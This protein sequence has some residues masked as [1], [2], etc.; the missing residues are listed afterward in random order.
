M[1]MAW[2]ASAAV[3]LQVVTVTV[4]GSTAQSK[5]RDRSRAKRKTRSG[6]T[7]FAIVTTTTAPTA[8]ATAQAGGAGLGDVLFP[9]DGNSGYDV[10]DYDLS[11]R[12]DDVP[13]GMIHG[14]ARIRLVPHAL[15]DADKAG[16][17]SAFHLDLHSLIVDRVTVGGDP[18]GFSRVDDE[19]IVTPRRPL[20]DGVEQTVVVTYAGQPET[21]ADGGSPIGLGW[22]PADGPKATY[23]LSEPNGAKNWFPANDHPLDKAT[24]T[25]RLDVPVPYQALANGTLVSSSNTASRSMSVWRMNQPMATYLATVHVGAF[26]RVQHFGARVPVTDWYLRGASFNRSAFAAQP[27]M[28]NWLEGL[29]GPY[30]F[31]SY[32]AVVTDGPRPLALETQSLSTFF[33]HATSEAAVVHELSHQWFGD[34]VSVARWDDVWLNEGFATYLER[35]WRERS[36]GPAAFEDNMR[37]AYDAVRSGASGPVRVLTRDELFG[38]STYLRGALVLHALRRNYGDAVFENVLRAYYVKFAGRNATS[39]DFF[40]VVGEV[41]GSAALGT[42]RHWAVDP[43]V[44]PYGS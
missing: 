19:L 15:H 36:I 20:L 31:E 43:V 12:L 25:F 35:M 40:A 21:I 7:G 42:V 16:A 5:A 9:T 27:A 4:G 23:V 41:A 30:P 17:L 6:G 38:R 34:S 11:V 1:V 3:F 8:S 24:F 2:V 10:V 29:I 26:E 39:E 44:P 13:A 14:V 18:A 32:G 37:T 22:Q 33:T 28:L